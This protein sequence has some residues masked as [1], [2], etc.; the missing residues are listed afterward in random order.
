MVRSTARQSETAALPASRHLP[1]GHLAVFGDLKRRVSPNMFC[2]QP[3]R[4]NHPQ[5]PH[6]RAVCRCRCGHNDLQSAAFA[7]TFISPR[8]PCRLPSH[9]ASFCLGNSNLWNRTGGACGEWQGTAPTSHPGHAAGSDAAP[10]SWSRRHQ[11]APTAR[12]R[13]ARCC[14]LRA[15]GSPQYLLRSRTSGPCLRLNSAPFA[16]VTGRRG[17][18]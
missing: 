2:Q 1:G 4:R 3:P 13:S 11:A 10:G 9:L 17:C 18:W 5:P 16:A 12:P 8:A 6:M 15:G 7:P 14:S